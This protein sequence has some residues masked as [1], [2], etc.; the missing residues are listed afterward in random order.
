[1]ATFQPS[2]IFSK[3]NT[4]STSLQPSGSILNVNPVKCLRSV[5]FSSGMYIPFGYLYGHACQISASFSA[6]KSPDTPNTR[7]MCPRGKLSSHLSNLTNTIILFV[8]G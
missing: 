4:S 5:F 7:S 8:V 1:M 3:V 2:S 6:S